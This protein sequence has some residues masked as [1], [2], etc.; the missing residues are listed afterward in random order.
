MSV[1]EPTWIVAD[2]LLQPRPEEEREALTQTE[3]RELYRTHREK[4]FEGLCS[5][6]QPPRDFGMLNAVKTIQ[7]RDGGKKDLVEERDN[8]FKKNVLK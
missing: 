5:L 1:G 7:W 6:R 4:S 8:N 3:R 2:E